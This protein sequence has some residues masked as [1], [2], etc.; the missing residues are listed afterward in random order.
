M[1]L[2]Q[3]DPARLCRFSFLGGFAM[4]RRLHLDMKISA[5]TKKKTT[6]VHA[7]L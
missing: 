4:K 1:V 3:V 5:T 6:A 2:R 7:L